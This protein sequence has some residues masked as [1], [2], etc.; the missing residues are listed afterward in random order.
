MQSEEK[1]I[2]ARLMDKVK[3]SKTRNKI[4][5][6]EFLT[7]YEKD[8]IQK[9]LNKMKFKNYLFFGGYGEAEAQLLII[10][11]EKFDK[12]IVDKNLNSIIKAIKIKLP[13]ELEGK[14]N[15]R[16][17]LGSVMKTGLNRNRIGDIIVHECE[18]YI[19]VLEENSMYIAEFLQGMTRFSKSKIEIVDFQDIRIKPQEFEERKITTSSM[20]IDNIVSE[21]IKLSRSRTTE[22]LIQEK[23]F[24]NSKVETKPS[25]L[26]QEGDIIA[27]RGKGKFLI[28]NVI[29]DNKKGKNVVLVKKYK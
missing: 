15:H 2:I 29:G 28:E 17:Y 23:V 7:I 13:K 1:L 25:K 8:I 21:I 27:V 18:A 19:L 9:E 5:H 26:V 20:R 10:Y 3:I 22:L 4:V 24:I 16:D 11:P 14:Y 6:T 12:E